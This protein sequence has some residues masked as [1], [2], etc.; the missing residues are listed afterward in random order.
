MSIWPHAKICFTHTWTLIHDINVRLSVCQ[1]G[2]KV[3]GVRQVTA[4][5]GIAYLSLW[6]FIDWCIHCLL[7]YWFWC[8]F[9]CARVY[10]WHIVCASAC[11]CDCE[12]VRVC[13][14]TKERILDAMWRKMLFMSKL[15]EMIKTKKNRKE[16]I[17]ECLW[18]IFSISGG[19][20]WRY[21]RFSIRCQETVSLKNNRVP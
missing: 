3:E 11:M 17:K 20:N 13:V 21:F 6:L 4:S 2:C 12:C 16:N 18:R 5:S 1:L 14:R 8:S 9:V 15:I 19:W 10:A 7:F